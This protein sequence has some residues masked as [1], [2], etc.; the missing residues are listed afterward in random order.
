MSDKPQLKARFR[1][2]GSFFVYR[3][4][5]PGAD[6]FDSRN[7]PVNVTDP[8]PQYWGDSGRFSA[9][10]HLISRE[11]VPVIGPSTIPA[12]EL[13]RCVGNLYYEKY[14]NGN[15]NLSGPLA[16]ESF[17]LSRHAGD[18]SVAAALLGHYFITDKAK[19]M[20]YGLA[21][22]EDM[23]DVVEAAILNVVH[24]LSYAAPNGQPPDDDDGLPEPFEFIRDIQTENTGGGCMVDVIT[25]KSGKVVTISGDAVAVWP[26]AAAWQSSAGELGYIALEV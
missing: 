26:S 4:D 23:D 17:Y 19:N 6:L 20:A 22:D 10:S 12:V 21:D 15:C 24:M 3:S 16:G 7:H 14:N 2:D 5:D 9:L 1:P 13:F 25:L 11:L 8:A 18:L